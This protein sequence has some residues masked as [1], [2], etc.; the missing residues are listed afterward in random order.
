MKHLFSK[1][2]GNAYCLRAMFICAL[3]LVVTSCEKNESS[4][5]KSESVPEARIEAPKKQKM[6]VVESEPMGE[7]IDEGSK[8]EPKDVAEE[9]K[10]NSSDAE[11]AVEIVTDP[12]LIKVPNG[13]GRPKRGDKIYTFKNLPKDGCGEYWV[14]SNDGTVGRLSVCRDEH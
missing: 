4:A 7:V 11:E 9:P 1:E 3:A 10:T 14:R 2:S 12:S 5:G 13:S 8:P 6:P